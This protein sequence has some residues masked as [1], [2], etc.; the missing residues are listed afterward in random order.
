M[1]IDRMPAWQLQNAFRNQGQV[2]N[3]EEVIKGKH[4]DEKVAEDAAEA[5]VRNAKP[6][7]KNAYKI[8]I[9]KTLVK[10]ALLQNSRLF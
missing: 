9:T 3:A 10:R 5:A 7:S 6:L 2:S 8:E 1:E 4:L